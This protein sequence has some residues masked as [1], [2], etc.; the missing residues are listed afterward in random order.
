MKRKEQE[1]NNNK[2]IIIVLATVIA[3]LLIVIG[4]LTIKGHFLDDDYYERYNDQEIY[5]DNLD[6]EGEETVPSNPDSSNENNPSTDNDTTK[7]ITKT[8]ALNIALKDLKISQSNIYDVSVELD[9][10]YNQTV[11]DIDFNYKNYEYE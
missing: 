10:K 9:Y 4:F 3:I 11:Y 8:E 6:D 5:N 1:K 2:V 7:Y